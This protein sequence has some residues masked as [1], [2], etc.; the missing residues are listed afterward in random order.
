MARITEVTY[1]RVL[2]VEK[3]EPAR[4]SATATVE[5][6]ED[7]EDVLDDLKAWVEDKLN[8]RPLR[9][10]VAE[11]FAPYTKAIR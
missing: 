5:E 6:W 3:F 4:V 2:Q 7:P 10:S 9:E 8:D 1:Q 11:T